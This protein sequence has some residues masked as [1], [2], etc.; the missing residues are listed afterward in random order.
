[1]PNSRLR[2]AAGLALD[3]ESKMPKFN[4]ISDTRWTI[5]ETGGMYDIDNHWSR[6]WQIWAGGIEAEILQHGNNFHL[7]LGFKNTRRPFHQSN[8]SSLSAAKRSAANRIAVA[9]KTHFFNM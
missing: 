8:H 3:G 1:M 2:P 7:I 5:S 4:T 6:E 9:E